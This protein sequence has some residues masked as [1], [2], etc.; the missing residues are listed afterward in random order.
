M[1]AL[2]KIPQ[3]YKKKG[4]VGCGVCVI[5]Q[6]FNINITGVTVTSTTATITFTHPFDITNFSVKYDGSTAY[7]SSSPIVLTGLNSKTQYSVYITASTTHGNTTSNT[8]TFYTAMPPPTFIY[9]NATDTTITSSF[10]AIGGE[11]MY[12]TGIVGNPQEFVGYDSPIT[13]TG[14]TSGHTYQIY[15]ATRDPNGVYPDSEKITYKMNT[16]PNIPQ[17]IN[18]IG[19]STVVYTTFNIIPNYNTYLLTMSDN[20]T[21]QAVTTSPVDFVNVP[22]DTTQNLYEIA[23]DSTGVFGR[24]IS[25]PYSVLTYGNSFPSPNILTGDGQTSSTSTTIVLYFETYKIYTSYSIFVGANRIDNITS[26]PY[27]ITDLSPYTTYYVFVQGTDST[28][29]IPDNDGVVVPITTQP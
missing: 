18:A 15:I 28:G 21:R 29:H 19:Y 2:R 16:S 23:D 24:V 4:Y 22:S 1:P 26:S 27:T 17:I 8:V 10:T 12:V 3:V 25:A 5:G 14:L 6:N 7:S 20:A 13:V 11:Q 9:Y